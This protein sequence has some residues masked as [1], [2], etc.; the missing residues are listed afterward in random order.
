[1]RS[2]LT[3]LFVLYVSLVAGVLPP[4]SVPTPVSVFGFEPGAE[5]Q[6]ATYE[7]VVE[8]F[9]RVAAASDRVE[10]VDA[11]ETSQGRR[12]TFAL[13]SSPANLANIGRLREIAQRLAHPSDLSDAEAHTLAREGRVFVHIDGGL[14]STE[15]AAPQH[16]ALL[17]DRLM[18]TA[19]EPETASILDNVVLMLWPTINPDGHQMVA[20]WRMANPGTSGRGVSMPTLYQEFVGHDNNRDAYMLNMV[21]SRAVEYAWRQWEPQIIYVH[22]QS[23]PFPTRIWLPPFAE[24]IATHAPYLMSRVVNALGMAIALGL[25]ERGQVG[26]T[27]M[28]TGYDAWYPGYIDYL[29]M[30]KNIAAFWTETQGRN[31]DS[32]LDDIR[33]GMRRPQ[34]LYASPWLGGTWRLRDA[35]E[36]METASL[37]VLDFAARYKDDL[38]FDR[39]LSGRDQIASGRSLAPYAY[40]VPQQQR[41]PV[42]AVELLRRLA[43]SGVR[44]SHLVEATVFEGE[45]FPAGTWVVPTDQE[46]AALAREVLDVQMYPEIR[47]SPDGPRDQPYDAAGWT[48]PLAMG[49]RV[50]PVAAP[51]TGEARAALQPLVPAEV[52]GAAPRPYESSAVAD[53]SPFDSV[54]GLGFDAVPAARA[55]VPLPGRLVGS[56]P[57]V[58]VNP[59]ENNAFRFLNHAW[60]SGAEVRFAA[61]RDPRYVVTGLSTADVEGLVEDLAI[62][63]ERTDVRG[64]V[65]PRPRIGLYDVPTSIDQGWTRWVLEQ[66]GFDYVPVSGAALEAGSIGRDVDVLIVTD[67]SRGVLAGGRGRGRGGRGARPT[68]LTPADQARVAGLDAFVRGGGTL[69]CLNRCANFA[70]EHLELS[71]R[72]SLEGVGRQAFSASGSLLR[73]APDTTHQVMAGMPDEA[74]VFFDSSPAFETGDDF[75]GTVLAR[76]QSD[77]SPLLSGFLLGESYLQGKAAAVDVRHG[78]GHVVLIGFRPQWR[79]QPFGTFRV[80]FNAAIFVR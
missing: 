69:V 54:P 76:Y 51:L 11:G 62:T 72:N 20:E 26:A 18:Q 74:A 61:G 30:F 63:A 41:D 7:Q 64:D 43:F 1:M 2:A 65:L 16:T 55:V 36:Y 6:L 25:E 57:A 44:I 28:G 3:P 8:Y 70:I 5:N 21:E 37:S 67:E 79:G 48:L 68:E 49:V 34:S 38:L 60:A 73:V 56:G 78:E 77:G 17:L 50:V 10:L 80:L 46:F 23:S 29:P 32:T 27:H 45:T 42:A 15:V 71:V 12:F 19:D 14:H 9:R 59:S 31:G 40:V 58:A 39:Y 13:V 22:H 24:P 52:G 35:V 33:S 47:S 75:T 66:Y 53:A 4:Q